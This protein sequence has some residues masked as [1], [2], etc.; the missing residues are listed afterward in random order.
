MKAVINNRI[1]LNCNKDSELEARLIMNLRYEISQEPISPYPLVINNVTRVTPTVVSIPSGRL[2]LVPSS[3]ELVDKRL[4]VP[5]VIPAL[6]AT[7]RPDQQNAVEFL[8]DCGLIEA[9]P[10]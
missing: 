5:A 10:G 8:T 6:K 1:F 9:Q 4:N 7:L 2:D 3:Y